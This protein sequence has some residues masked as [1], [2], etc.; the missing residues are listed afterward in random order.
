MLYNI[1][2]FCLIIRRFQHIPTLYYCS[3][4]SIRQFYANFH[5]KAYFQH[6]IIGSLPKT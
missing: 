1:F 3:F 2:Y 6:Q 4:V 5:N